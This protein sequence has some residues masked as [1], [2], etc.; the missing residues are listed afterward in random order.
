MTFY[1]RVFVW[2][3][4]STVKFFGVGTLSHQNRCASPSSPSTVRPMLS[5]WRSPLCKGEQSQQYVEH[6]TYVE[7]TNGVTYVDAHTY[8]IRW[9]G[10]RIEILH[11]SR[12]AEVR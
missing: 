9:I 7:P 12:A 1:L 2:H 3:V 4:N 6:S 5:A 8:V 10:V 11:A